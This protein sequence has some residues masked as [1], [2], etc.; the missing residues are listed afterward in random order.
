MAGIET[1]ILQEDELPKVLEIVS[2][3]GERIFYMIKPA[4]R[5]FGACLQGV[6]QS[7]RN[8]LMQQG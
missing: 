5:K 7:L 4:G 1:L 8:T 2:H 6:D 3:A